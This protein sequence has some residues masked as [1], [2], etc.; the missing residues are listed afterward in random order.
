MGECHPTVNSLFEHIILHANIVC[1]R[2]KT[3]AVKQR[4]EKGFK[5]EHTALP[6]VVL[7]QNHAGSVPFALAD[8]LLNAPGSS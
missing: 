1:E 4:M 5:M 6:S 7:L 8:V 2:R 3:L